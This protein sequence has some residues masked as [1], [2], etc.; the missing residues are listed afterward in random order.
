MMMNKTD[1][2]FSPDINQLIVERLKSYPKVV[3]ELAIKAIKLAEKLPEATVY[4]QLQTLTRDAAR[5]H[6]GDL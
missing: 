6:E 4:E 5:K 2:T 3:S 1:L